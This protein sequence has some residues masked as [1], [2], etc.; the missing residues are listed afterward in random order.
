MTEQ[1]WILIVDD[2]T[3]IQEAMAEIVAT[4]GYQVE[5]AADGAEAIEIL[6]RRGPPA[7]VIVDLLMPGIVGHELLEYL[8]SEQALR[9][10]PV[11]I[12]SAS[13]HLAPEGYRVFAKPFSARTLVRFIH[14]ELDAR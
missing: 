2:D 14:G 8:E 11:A 9:D 6:E 10:V 4:E 5:V 13:P 3:D 1:R 12:V 7:S